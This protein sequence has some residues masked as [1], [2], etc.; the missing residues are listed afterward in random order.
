[1]NEI[2]SQ[3]SKSLGFDVRLFDADR[4]TTLAYCES[5]REAGIV[6]DDEADQIISCL[7]RIRLDELLPS[8]CEDVHT[9]LEEALIKRVGSAASKLHAG[10]SRNDQVATALRLWLTSEIDELRAQLGRV[11]ARLLEQ[12]ERDL[13][14]VMPG[15]TH[16]QRAQPVLL[17]HWCLAYFE[18]L[19]RDDE[20]LLECRKRTNI[21]PLGSAALAGTSY[22]IDRDKLARRLRIPALCRNSLDAVADRDFCIEFLSTASLA[23]T[24]LSRLAED[25]ILFCSREFGFVELADSV[26]MGSNLLPQKKNPGALELIRAKSGRVIGDLTGFLCAMKALP[27][28]YNQD[29]QEDKEAVFDAADTLFDSLQVMELMLKN[30]K[31]NGQRMRAAACEGFLNATEAADYLVRRGT[32]FRKAHDI[33]GQWVL[34]A[35][36]QGVELS[37]LSL[38]DL[39]TVHPEV[40][41]D[42]YRALSL[43]RTIQSKGVSGGTSLPRIKEA[44]AE[45]KMYLCGKESV[46]DERSPQESFPLELL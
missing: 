38:A 10:R 43:E 41:N 4:R 37:D 8:N 32:P 13:G 18:M 27:L 46:R 16:L 21:M 28:S 23:M 40:D 36:E 22:P 9:L 6:T 33:V 45:A 30:L 3:F 44:L 25:L 29:L 42:F 39:H 20:R 2:V 1:L 11:Q 12:A 19:R 5:L 14:I 15:Y 35:V 26:A 7:K 31:W 24:H 34:R 17:S